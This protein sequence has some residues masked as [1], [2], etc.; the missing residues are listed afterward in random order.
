MNERTY[1]KVFRA[2]G[3][4]VAAILLLFAGFYIYLCYETA[5]GEFGL[6]L[7]PLVFGVPLVTLESI[8]F[9]LKFFFFEG[10]MC[11]GRT[12]YALKGIELALSATALLCIPLS[13]FRPLAFL[14]AVAILLTVFVPILWIIERILKKRM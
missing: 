7:L 6:F 9:S 4:A 3:I 13:F 8:V 1:R 11:G 5:W 2:I 10:E 14:M 12:Y